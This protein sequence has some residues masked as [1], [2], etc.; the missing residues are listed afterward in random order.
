[1]NIFLQTAQF[2]NTC[3]QIEHTVL[4]LD[5]LLVILPT[6]NLSAYT[7]VGLFACSHSV[8]SIDFSARIVHFRWRVKMSYCKRQKLSRSSGGGGAL[9]NLYP[10]WEHG[11]KAKSNNELQHFCKKKIHLHQT[12]DVEITLQLNTIIIKSPYCS[13][14]YAHT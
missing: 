14:R 3:I 1:M 4:N 7:Y 5:T 8:Y 9:V 2:T 13:T 6:S 12:T 11:G 10:A